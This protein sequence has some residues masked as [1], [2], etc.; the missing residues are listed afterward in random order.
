M[1]KLKDVDLLVAV[2]ELSLDRK[3]VHKSWLTSRVPP[4]TASELSKK[5]SR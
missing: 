3:M 5:W 4:D 2:L 1:T